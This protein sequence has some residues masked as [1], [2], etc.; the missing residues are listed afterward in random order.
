MYLC[1]QHQLLWP[2]L[3][4]IRAG[5]LNLTLDYRICLQPDQH[6]SKLLLQLLKKFSMPD[7]RVG[8]RV[9]PHSQEAPSSLAMAEKALELK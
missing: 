9:L 6:L 1:L 8:V 3:H 7:L 2:S 5:Q 4:L